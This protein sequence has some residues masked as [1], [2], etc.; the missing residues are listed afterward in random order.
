MG[1]GVKSFEQNNKTIYTIGAFPDYNEALDTQIEMKDLGVKTPKIIA[2]NN[3]EEIDTDK[4]LE[5]IK[6]Q[7]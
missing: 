3:G 4:A 2:F 6:T 7:K 5:L 1:R